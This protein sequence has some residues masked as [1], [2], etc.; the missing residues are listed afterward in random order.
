MSGKDHTEGLCHWVLSGNRDF[1]LLIFA[2]VI[3]NYLFIIFYLLKKCCI[4]WVNHLQGVN[5]LIDRNAQV[6]GEIVEFSS[7]PEDTPFWNVSSIWRHFCNPW[8][9]IGKMYILKFRKSIE[10]FLMSSNF[11]LIC[12]IILQI[13]NVTFLHFCLSFLPLW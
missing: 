3:F 10:N 7:W 11:N 13:F 12:N 9:W 2:S 4:E 8:F 5:I 1:W 6:A